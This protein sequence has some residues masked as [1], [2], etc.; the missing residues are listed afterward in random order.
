[1]NKLPERWLPYKPIGARIKGTPFIAF[2]V[3]LKE[4][5]NNQVSPDERFSPEM[6]L[7]N[8]PDLSLV[9]DLTNTNRYYNKTEFTKNRV[10][11]EKINCPGHQIPDSRIVTR[12]FNVVDSFLKRK[13]DALIGVH[14]T[15]GVN[16]TGY[17]ICRYMIQRL[18]KKPEEAIAD[19]AA[20]RGHPIEREN[21]IADLGRDLEEVPYFVT[22]KFMKNPPE[23][24][25]VYR[26]ES[27]VRNRSNS[28][29]DY[30]RRGYS[31]S[32]NFRGRFNRKHHTS[33]PYSRYQQNHTTFNNAQSSSSSFNTNQGDNNLASDFQTYS[34]HRRHVSGNM[35]DSRRYASDDQYSQRG[36]NTFRGNFGR[37]RQES[38]YTNRRT[39]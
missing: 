38:N 7:S 16:R 2:K 28:S 29:N 31:K 4:R 5:L 18:G 15:H 24:K 10:L 14:C 36:R 8:F 22:E 33:N 35:Q 23:D 3:P 19:F 20:A 17:F 25:H 21:Y 32:V 26:N 6:L 34:R 37:G 30:H 39:D 11:H 1:M 13:P 27:S 9:V 12:F